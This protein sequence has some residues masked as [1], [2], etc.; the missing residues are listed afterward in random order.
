MTSLKGPICKM[1]QTVSIRA[2]IVSVS[3]SFKFRVHCFRTY[4]QLTVVTTTKL[5]LAQISPKII[6]M[7]FGE[8]FFL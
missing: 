5:E 3:A 6:R 7:L 2:L 8:E 1:I 4:P